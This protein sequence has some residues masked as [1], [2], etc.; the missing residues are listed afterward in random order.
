MVVVMDKRLLWVGCRKVCGVGC[1][2]EVSVVGIGGGRPV[3][4]VG[5]TRLVVVGSR[6]EM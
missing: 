3:L 5:G 2:G 6:Q 4:L 1:S